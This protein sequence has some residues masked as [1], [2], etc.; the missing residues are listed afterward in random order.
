MNTRKMRKVA[1]TRI[2]I[3]ATFAIC[4]DQRMKL[5]PRLRALCRDGLDDDRHR[6]VERDLDLLASRQHDLLPLRGHGHAGADDGAGGRALPDVALAS[7]NAAQDPARH[8]AAADLE[9][10][11]LGVALPFKP[12]GRGGDRVALSV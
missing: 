7:E 8:R 1:W 3:P 4:Q 11:L 6:T 12:E 2:G 9:S 10:A 5:L